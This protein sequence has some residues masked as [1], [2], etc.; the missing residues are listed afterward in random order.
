MKKTINISETVYKEIK[1]EAE[2]KNQTIGNFISLM[3]INYYKRSE[4]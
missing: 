1:Q 3:F 4:K 2:R